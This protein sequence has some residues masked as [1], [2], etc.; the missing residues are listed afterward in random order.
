MDAKT[1]VGRFGLQADS[2]IWLLARGCHQPSS[3]AGGDDARS[4][5]YKDDA[6]ISTQPISYG[7]NQIT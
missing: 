1:R 6:G 7:P 4:S 2:T 5:S 3:F